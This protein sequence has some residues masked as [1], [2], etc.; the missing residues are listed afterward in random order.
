M[1]ASGDASE[2]GRR[3]LKT[4]EWIAVDFRRRRRKASGKFDGSPVSK[5]ARVS[6]RDENCATFAR[7]CRGTRGKRL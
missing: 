6:A 7:Q 5:A 2:I 4:L 1:A 3:D